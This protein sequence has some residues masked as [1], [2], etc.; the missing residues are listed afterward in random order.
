MR[1]LLLFSLPFGIGTLL[2]QYLLREEWRSW[3]AAGVLA[4]GF[5]ASFLAGRRRKAVRI[6]AVGLTIGI[7][8][9]SGYAALFLK[10]AETL[11]GTED[12]VTAELMDYAEE[13][14]YGTRCKVKILDSG[15][16]GKGMYYGGYSLLDLEPGDRIRAKV[17]YY[18]A[19]TLAGEHSTYYTSQGIFLRL[20]GKEEEYM[21]GRAG[22]LRY[23]PQRLSKRLKDTASAI[24]AEP[25]IGFITALLTGE[26]SGLDEQSSTD[27]SEAGLMHITAVS[28]LHCG[29]LIGLIGILTFRRQRLTAALG[30]PVLLLYMAMA[31]CTPSVVR[32]CVMVG[33]ALL[34][35]LLGREG[36]SPT[37]LAGALLVILLANPFAVASVS[38][39][40]SFAAVAGLLL[41]A[42]KIYAA[43]SEYRPKRNWTLGGIWNF[44][45]GTLSASFGVMLLT[46]PLSAVYFGSLSL[47]SPLANLMVLWIAPVLFAAALL[48]TAGCAVWPSLAPLAAVPE[49]LTRYVLWTAG[50]LAKLP[51]HSVHFTGPA[52]VLWLL[53][54]YV[55]LA[56]CAISQDRRRKYAVAAIAAIVS[57]A[58]VR[59]IPVMAMR[60]GELT[61]V[62]VDVGQGAA[63]LLHS[64][65]ITALVDCGSLNVAS[66][67]GAAVANVMEAYG[68]DRLDCVALTHYHEDH[69]GGLGELM[70]RVEVGKLLAP[71]M[72]GS[73]NQADLQREVLA[74]AERYQVPVTYVEQPTEVELGLSLLTVYP[75][76]SEGDTNEEG[77]TF[78]CTAGDFDVLITG[79]M[80]GS[81]ERKLIET[82]ELPDIEVLMVGH[83][84]SK[85]STS[86][87]LLEAVRPEVGVISVGANNRFGH[88]TAEAMER[89]AAA[90]MTLYRTDLQGNILIRLH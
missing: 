15:L 56:I 16:R 13:S 45:L 78:L 73:D 24:Y 40:L 46:A 39:Q 88:P 80:A 75:P 90:G 43:L 72:L 85:Y 25:A 66:G 32:S 67:P 37:S 29:F 10:P 74:L 89:M 84:G 69:A 34:A 12:T 48:V 76:V 71:Q 79:D 41:P 86:E 44:F 42:S 50:F 20:Y 31:G 35:P 83:H 27:L 52:I 4:A 17:K 51:G 54:V 70:S 6:S 28:G 64:D 36:D 19:A 30:Y 49:L 11:V 55:M 57:L 2:C 21:L 3:A 23:L 33:F 60:G 18:S 53:F 5:V 26:R 9:F 62:A 59:A 1:K 87:E 38:L 68:W 47:I 63:T 77:L 14:G 22:S 8:W 82:Y 61:I 7:L 65:T 81:T 58:E